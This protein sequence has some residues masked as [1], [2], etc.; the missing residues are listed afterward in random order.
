MDKESEPRRARSVEEMNFAASLQPCPTCG[1]R[2]VEKFQLFGDGDVWTIAG[3][4]PSCATKRAFSFATTGVPYQ[5]LPKPYE[6]GPGPSQLLEAD[7]FRAELARVAPAIHE[8]PTKLAAVAWHA[9]LAAIDIALTSLN[10]L[11]KLA[12][13]DLAALVAE[14]DRTMATAKR[15]TADAGRI[16]ALGR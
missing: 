10:E 15:Y 11:I 12:P 9:S 8:D 7:Q 6:L 4:C 13:A 2:D 5:T 14:R 3:P 1:S 16:Q